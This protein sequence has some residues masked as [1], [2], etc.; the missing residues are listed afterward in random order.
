[1]ERPAERALANDSWCSWAGCLAA[2]QPIRCETVCS[3][4][5]IC[6]SLS[7]TSV[8]IKNL[9]GSGTS[10]IRLGHGTRPWHVA[11]LLV[12]GA[13]L[14]GPAEAQG[15]EP[16]SRIAV[17]VEGSVRVNRDGLNEYWSAG[18]GSL[19]RVAAPFYVGSAALT[20]RRAPFRPVVA[21]VYDMDMIIV[22]AEWNGDVDLGRG[23]QASAGVQV[24]NATID[25][26]LEESRLFLIQESE[27]LAG[28]QAALR[29]HLGRGIGAV[30]SMSHQRLFTHIPVHLT[31]AGA[32][33]EYSFD[34]PR[35]LEEV[36]R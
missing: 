33:L 32:G 4:R 7:G 23:T 30:V 24:G 1:M 28:G 16:F 35:W 26:H 18:A 10:N 27:F 36:L 12:C 5:C 15:P 6:P 25:F 22:A 9:G 13:F 34:T 31:Y 3:L 14:A 17:S 29:V 19:V 20:V 11:G 21:D 8:T 2:S